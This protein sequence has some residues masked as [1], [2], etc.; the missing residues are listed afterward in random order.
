[1]SE[2]AKATSRRHGL[3]DV[4]LR[5]KQAFA[6]KFFFC[7]QYTRMFGTLLEP[8]LIFRMQCLRFRPTGQSSDH[9]IRTFL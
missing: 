3:V 9:S 7:C 6:G 2:L 1:M 4:R 5:Y 8:D